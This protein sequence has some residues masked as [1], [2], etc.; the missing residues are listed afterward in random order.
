MTLEIFTTSALR[1][2][3]LDERRRERLCRLPKVI[4][5]GPSS[6]GSPVMSPLW[7]LDGI[8]VIPIFAATSARNDI[9]GSPAKSDWSLGPELLPLRRDD[10]HDETEHVA[11]THLVPF[12]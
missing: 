11:P 12:L 6:T 8:V 1:R 4:P 3:D 2:R 9:L 5:P 10:D 7:K